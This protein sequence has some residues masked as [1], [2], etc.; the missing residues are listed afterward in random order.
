MKNIHPNF[1]YLFILLRFQ[2]VLMSVFTLT[3]ICHWIGLLDVV[4]YN[5]LIIT[6]LSILVFGGFGIQLV[7]QKISMELMKQ[8]RNAISMAEHVIL[9]NLEK[10]KI[11]SSQQEGVSDILQQ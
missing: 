8:T 2:F 1:R 10:E 7:Y 9:K 4:W 11:N 6:Q 5:Q 3:A